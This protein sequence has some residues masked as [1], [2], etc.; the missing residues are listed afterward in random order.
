VLLSPIKEFRESFD[1]SILNDN[2]A[3][4]SSEQGKH[5]EF[6]EKFGN[7]K[8]ATFVS[9]DK[10]NEERID[11]VNARC[12]TCL[13][14]ERTSTKNLDIGFTCSECSKKGNTVFMEINTTAWDVIAKEKREKLRE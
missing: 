3:T 4:L 7:L 8:P 11:I 6:H 1:P 13:T 2:M 5:K 12:P 9:A 14:V 10:L